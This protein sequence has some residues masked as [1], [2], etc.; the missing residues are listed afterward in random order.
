MTAGG[1]DV[2]EWDFFVSYQQAD[3]GWAEWI[4][5]Q[6]ENAG[7]S[8]LLQAWDFVPGTNWITLMQDGVTRS[9]RVIAVLSDAY[10]GSVFG[11]AEWQ[12]IWALDPAGAA[13]RVIPVRV[14]DCERPG[15]LGGIAGIDLFGIPEPQALQRLQ[16]AI[17]QALAGRAKPL[18]PP[19]FPATAVGS[20]STGTESSAAT[21][22]TPVPRTTASDPGAGVPGSR[23]A[24]TRSTSAAARAYRSATTTLRSTGGEAQFIRNW[25][26]TSGAARN[27]QTERQVSL[28]ADA[29]ALVASTSFMLC[30]LAAATAPHG[31]LGGASHAFSAT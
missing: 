17:N 20:T 21:G 9:A 24:N 29:K 14:A 10:I 26:N 1:P 18:S 15:L 25:P 4:A 27:H 2:T 5:W 3:R 11:A 22:G 31:V 30:D 19:S 12:A 7:H 23:A 6:L 28:S 16:D 13:R 8:A